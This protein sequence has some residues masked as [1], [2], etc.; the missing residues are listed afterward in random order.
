MIDRKLLMVVIFF[1]D[2][3]RA[4]DLTLKLLKRYCYEKIQQFTTN[5]QKMLETTTGQFVFC[6]PLANGGIITNIDTM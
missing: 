1:D 4:N 6:N 2:K 3:Q 5:G